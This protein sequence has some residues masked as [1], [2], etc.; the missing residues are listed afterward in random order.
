M[1]DYLW[2]GFFFHD[3]LSFSVFKRFNQF[4]ETWYAMSAFERSLRNLSYSSGK[5]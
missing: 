2:S 4:V 5:T 3:A 1:V